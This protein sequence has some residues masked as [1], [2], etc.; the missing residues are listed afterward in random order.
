MGNPT[1]VVFMA[2][3][4]DHAA[5]AFLVLTQKAGVG[6]NHV[7]TMHSITGEGQS[8]IHQHQVVAVL[9]HTSVLADLMQTPQGDNPEAG[10]LFFAGSRVVSHEKNV[11]RKTVCV[12]R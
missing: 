2:M 5:N 1:D 8:G 11:S 12:S 3:G 6:Q 10:L 9:E 7:H 4:H